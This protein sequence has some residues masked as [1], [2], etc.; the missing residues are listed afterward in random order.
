MW[1][2]ACAANM[3]S[4][5]TVRIMGH[6]IRGIGSL[7]S[8]RREMGLTCILTERFST[9]CG[10][11]TSIRK[12]VVEAVFCLFSDGSFVEMKCY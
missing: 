9:T 5:H 6:S 3:F 2:S 8:M 10:L 12:K 4:G 11:I 1:N 7:S